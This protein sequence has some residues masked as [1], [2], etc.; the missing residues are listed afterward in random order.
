M[1]NVRAFKDTTLLRQPLNDQINGD[2][3]QPLPRPSSAFSASR[4]KR[5]PSGKRWVPARWQAS[6]RNASREALALAVASPSSPERNRSKAMRTNW[7]SETPSFRA[8]SFKSRSWQIEPLPDRQSQYTSPP[9][10]EGEWR[11]KKRIP[12]GS[13]RRTWPRFAL[14]LLAPMRTYL[15]VFHYAQGKADTPPGVGPQGGNVGKPGAE[16]DSGGPGGSRSPR[17]LLVH[18]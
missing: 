6:A 3:R 1:R 4:S 5:Q 9:L 15:V 7:A 2:F 11:E 8:R 16:V 17:P 10:G 13:S 14:R 18:P 12:E